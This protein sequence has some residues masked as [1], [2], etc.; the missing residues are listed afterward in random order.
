MI[1]IPIIILV[2]AALSLLVYAGATLYTRARNARWEA[3]FEP[4]LVKCPGEDIG[5]GARS[6]CNNGKLL[7]DGPEVDCGEC[8]GTGQ[9]EPKG[10]PH[11]QPMPPLGLME[12]L[13][14]PNANS[15]MICAVASRKWGDLVSGGPV[16][17][18]E[19]APFP[20]KTKRKAKAKIS[21]KPLKR[22]ARNGIVKER[23]K[24]RSR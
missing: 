7:Q 24:Q 4:E 18:E 1:V 2:L 21:A 12:D 11:A 13:N 5:D 20:K 17:R 23:S 10:N 6:V 9:V 22:A 16:D 3:S 19:T 8:G 15:N 14:L